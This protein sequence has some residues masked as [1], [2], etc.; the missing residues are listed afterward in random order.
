MIAT[1][2]AGHL[3]FRRHCGTRCSVWPA[4][5]RRSWAALRYEMISLASAQ[6]EEFGV[7]FRDV[8]AFE[9]L[10]LCILDRRPE[11]G[12]FHA[13]AA[14]RYLHGAAVRPQPE[15][16]WLHSPDPQFGAKVAAI[17]A[18]YTSPP[19]GSVVL[20]VDEKT[21]M[22][23]LGRPHPVRPAGPHRARWKAATTSDTEHAPSSPPSTRTRGRFSAESAPP[24]RPMTSWC[25]WRPS[26]ACIRPAMSTSCGTT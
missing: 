26:P 15:E 10:A 20:C 4:R 17:C 11:L 13:S 8:W 12:T 1:D 6:P 5:S 25:S 2:R 24:G 19:S 3:G 23:A 14:C 16:M 9:S 7:L 22:Q 21:G 18:L